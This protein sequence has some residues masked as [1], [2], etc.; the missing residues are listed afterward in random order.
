MTANVLYVVY[1]GAAEPLGQSLVVPTVKR[2]SSLGVRIG[3]VTFEKAGDLADEANI[4]RI[5]RELADAGVAWVPLRYHKWP[6]WPATL[7][8]VLS[9]VFHG[10][11]LGR[12]LGAEIVHARTFV[13]GV[14]GLLI[15]K[16]LRRALVYHNEGFYP[17]EQ[18]DGGVWRFGSPAHRFARFVE[19]RLYR[20]ADGIIV[21]SQ[22]ACAQVRG[23][24]VVA[25]RSTPVVVVRSCVDLDRFAWR[26]SL[27]W[28]PGSELRLVYVGSIGAR[29]V[30]ESVGQLLS[31]ALKRG[32]DAK[33]RV[34]TPVNPQVVD[35]LL[36]R[37]GVARGTWSVARVAHA[38]MP[39]EL[40]SQHA[41][42][43]VL[44]QGISEHGC[45]PTKVGE[46][47]AVG[48]PVVITPNISDTDEIIREDRVG[49]VIKGPEQSCCEDALDRL[50]D[51]IQDP[52]LPLRCRHAAE[53]HYSLTPAVE[54][55]RGLYDQ[56]LWQHR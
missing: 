19:Q 27:P 31:T 23:F 32:L 33:L 35:E 18:V 6:K 38:D 16:L 11:A 20:A 14:I 15:A 17:D 30:F 46:Y 8:D 26:G 53:R 47:W 42:L 52:E 49:V 1:W 51:L 45:S 25:A 48:L 24:P 5:R 12:S 39:R 41:G 56:L 3:L 28:R 37:A 7:F 2:L 22:R 50:L 40:A 55:Q 54:V 9:G 34:L 21:L 36:T 13:G 29:Y 4:S 10:A 43:M 44:T